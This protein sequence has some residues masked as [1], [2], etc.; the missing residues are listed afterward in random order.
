MIF[1]SIFVKD[2][3]ENVV[4]SG[5]GGKITLDLSFAPEGRH[6]AQ[7]FSVILEIFY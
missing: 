4:G 5:Y 2:L 1:M 3:P 7:R 6:D